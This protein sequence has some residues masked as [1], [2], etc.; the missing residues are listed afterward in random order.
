MAVLGTEPLTPDRYD[1]MK[2]VLF[3]DKRCK[4]TARKTHKWFASILAAAKA[5][6]DRLRCCLMNSGFV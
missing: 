1:A 2:R 4:M 3:P 5:H 6:K